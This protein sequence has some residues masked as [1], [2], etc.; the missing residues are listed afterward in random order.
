MNDM[1]MTDAQLA[2]G[3]RRNMPSEAQAGLR[4]RI[5]AE[6]EATSQERPMPALLGRLTD[7]DPVARRRALLV[8]AA[9]LLAIGLTAAGVVG[10]LLADRSTDPIPELSLEPPS[11]LAAF[12]RSTY[13]LMP[14]LPPLTMTAIA[15]G[16]TKSRIYVDGSGAVRI[17]TFGTLDATEP[18]TYKI[19]SGTTM[20]QFLVVGS[21]PVWYEQAGA[22]SED[23][24]VFVFA[25]MGAVR[26][27]SQAGCEVAVSPGE[28]YADTP[29]RLWRYVGL[30]E[31]AGRPTH[32]LSCA[33]DLWI[34]VATRL[35]LRSRGAVL[36]ASG[37]PIPG[38]FRTIEATQVEIGQPPAELFEMAPPAGIERI[39][40]AD[41]AC[42]TNPYCSASPRPVVTPPPAPADVEPPAKVDVVVAAA[43]AAS[44]DLPG[45]DVTVE[46]RNAKYPGNVTRVLHDGSGRFRTEWTF[47]GSSDPPSIMLSG[48]DYAYA[49]E[50]T[51]DGVVFWLDL[52][53]PRGDARRGSYPLAL[54]DDCP[55]GWQVVGVDLVRGRLADHLGC[56]GIIV[57]DQ[58][59]IDRETHLVVR[60]QLL[61]DEQ[62][63]T[64]VDEV[65]DL[66]LGELAPELFELPQDAD[67]RR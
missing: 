41:Y 12:A 59:W 61:R 6:V 55:G 18:E 33:D 66:R 44:K 60:V 3:L 53:S 20:G 64:D 1:R 35:T 36:D 22:I 57:P 52:A 43:L 4:A 30:E 14:A 47:E 10:A 9:A 63:G 65:I 15:D 32:H 31:V 42:A 27:P 13:D 39:A 7:A 67:I 25:T 50:M 62:Q 8:A 23:P 16:T 51:A 58:Y 54:P 5:L 19:L 34:D 37:A 48:D 56:P 21:R 46:H 17:E 26:G 38:Q 11:D 24:R 45:F 29:G 28:S 40:E 49:T 2:A